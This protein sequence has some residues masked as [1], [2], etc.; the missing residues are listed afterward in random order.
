[1]KYYNQNIL[2]LEYDELVPAV[3]NADNYQYHRKNE[4]I[5]V[6]GRGGNGREVL[7]D[8]ESLSTKHK[9]AV[10]K[11]YGDPYL[12]IKK[13]PVLD[14]V[15]LNRDYN[16]LDFYTK[17]RLP[18]GQPLP[19]EPVNYVL[20]YT[21]AATWLNAIAHYTSDKRALKRDLNIAVGEFW[22]MVSSLVISKN[23]DIP[24]SEKRLKLRLK[25]YQE[26]GYQSLV[27]T[28]RFANTNS[29]KRNDSIETV[30][31]YLYGQPNKPYE[32]DI[33]NQLEEVR[34]GKRVIVDEET[35]EVYDSKIFVKP[36]GKAISLS[37]ATVKNVLNTA[38]NK[39]ALHKVRASALE[40]SSKYTPHVHR[41][42]PEYSFSKITMDDI[43]IPFK[44]ENGSRVWS[45]QIFDVASGAVIG[46]A[47]GRDKNQE[48]F[49]EAV[50][51]MFRTIIMNGWCLPAEIEI[52]QHISS[53]LKGKENEQGVFEADL[54][55]TGAIFPFVRFCRGANPQEKRAE[56]FI[57]RKKFGVQNKRD[58]FQRRPFA[59]LEAN[60]ANEDTIGKIK[61]TYD[62]VV[63]NENSD[64]NEYNSQLHPKQDV[65]PG[66][67]RWDVLVNSQNPKLPLPN[68]EAIMRF[69]GEKSPSKIERSQFVKVKGKK[70]GLPIDVLNRVVG[71]DLDAY[72]L[73]INDKIS[74]IYLYEGAKFI[75]TAVHQSAFQEAAAEKTEL[76][77]SI[78]GKQYNFIDKHKETI[79][80]KIQSF[81]TLKEH[82]QEAKVFEMPVSKEF[83]VPAYQ[84]QYEEEEDFDYRKVM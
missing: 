18:T 46:K 43:S 58:G 13:Q 47:F 52:E 73:K 4:N 20:K 14:Y 56:G 76:D 29:K 44:L 19:I 7:I 60:R 26:N 39:V 53:T 79:K 45:Y 50:R 49:R 40:H 36:N 6:Y 25:D 57:R 35:G 75:S 33:Y 11:L 62:Q 27:E 28:W 61:Y 31:L 32:I 67:K 74:E 1:M 55:T 51:D 77:E 66:M 10:H 9:E 70:F 41:K 12:Y 37:L 3:M 22:T 59:K 63:N 80:G 81:I 30:I 24:T 21:D 38:I 64:I 23:I 71:M 82:K 34:Q 84:D 8:Y 54:L 69:I 16:A 42:A 15:K 2:C 78:A 68:L 5:T 72:F 83:T 48:L 65:Y 17:H